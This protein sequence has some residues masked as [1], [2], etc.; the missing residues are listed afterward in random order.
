MTVPLDDVCLLFATRLAMGALSVGASV[1]NLHAAF[2]AWV[3]LVYA[4]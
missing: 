4:S 1:A 2:S 3:Q